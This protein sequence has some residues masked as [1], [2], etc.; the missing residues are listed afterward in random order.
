MEKIYSTINNLIAETSGGILVLWAVAA[1]FFKDGLRW[2]GTK[3]AEGANSDLVKK[4][5]PSLEIKIDEKLQVFKSELKNDF[6]EEM[7]ELRESI[8]PHKVKGEL[9]SIREVIKNGD[10]ETILELQQIYLKQDFVNNK[11]K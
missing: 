7:R 11:I 8:K 9:A 10:T 2:V 5:M 6:K 3:I 1:V 4:F